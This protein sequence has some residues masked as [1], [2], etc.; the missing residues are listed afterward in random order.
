MKKIADEIIKN[1]DKHSKA[2]LE[3]GNMEVTAG[4][5]HLYA[6]TAR[7]RELEGVLGTVFEQVYDNPAIDEL[8]E[9]TL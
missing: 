6:L 8:V 7:V 9:K 2:K 1:I 3:E 5:F 4:E